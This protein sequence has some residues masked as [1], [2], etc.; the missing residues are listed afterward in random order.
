MALLLGSFG[1][2]TAGRLRRR[3]RPQKL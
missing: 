3:S 2:F 1:V